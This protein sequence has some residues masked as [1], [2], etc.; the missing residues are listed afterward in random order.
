MNWLWRRPNVTIPRRPKYPSSAASGSPLTEKYNGYSS[1]P[2]ITGYGRLILAE[3]DYDNCLQET[4]PFDQRKRALQHVSAQTLCIA[5]TLLARQ[6][7]GPGLTLLFF[8][9]PYRNYLRDPPYNPFM[10]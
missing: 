6:V 5:F 4:F 9:K 10:P 8:R 1:C 7:E 2:L 3:F